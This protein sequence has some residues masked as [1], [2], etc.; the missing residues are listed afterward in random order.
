[1]SSLV[2]R[3]RLRFQKEMLQQAPAR[4]RK[5][6]DDTSHH[7][8]HKDARSLGGVGVLAGTRSGGQL[9]E[10]L[11][12]LC[13]RTLGSVL[14]ACLWLSPSTAQAAPAH[15]DPLRRLDTHTPDAGAGDFRVTFGRH[16]SVSFPSTLPQDHLLSCPGLSPVLVWPS[17]WGRPGAGLCGCCPRSPRTPACAPRGSGV[18]SFGVALRLQALPAAPCGQTAATWHP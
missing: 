2:L 1:M 16:F 5:G 12:R 6:S 8:S 11:S 10:L 4:C 3:A 18:H 17:R 14:W 7:L 9:G 13:P 15:Q